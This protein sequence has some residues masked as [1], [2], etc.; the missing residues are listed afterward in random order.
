MRCM[1]LVTKIHLWDQKVNLY[2]K[3]T[4]K[5][6]KFINSLNT[7]IQ[8]LTHTLGSKT[9]Q[10]VRQNTCPYSAYLRVYKDEKQTQK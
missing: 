5:I 6:K 4:F 7:F 3:F 10:W 9:Q 2:I 1:K 8:C